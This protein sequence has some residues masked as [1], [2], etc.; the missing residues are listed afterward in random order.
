M[1]AIDGPSGVGKTTVAKLVAERLGLRAVST[2]ALYRAVALHFLRRGLNPEDLDEVREGLGNLEIWQEYTD[3]HIRTFLNGEDVTEE[4]DTV[5]VSDMA[6]RVAA[7]KEVREFL[8]DVQRRLAEGGA[9]VEGRD[10][11]TVV[12]PDADVKFFLD[13]TTGERAKRRYEQLRAEGEDIS[14]EDA[15]RDVKERDIRDSAREVA[16]L[17]RAADAIYI[18]TTHMTVEEVVNRILK[19]LKEVVP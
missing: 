3:G 15:L 19:I 16:P 14:Y 4:L 18:D 13:A 5:E 17:K 8:L 7:I 11:G 2:G 6:S 12:L 1:I 10:I 9:V